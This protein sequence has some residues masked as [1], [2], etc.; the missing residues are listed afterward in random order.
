[1]SCGGS[2]TPLEAGLALKARSSKA[3]AVETDIARSLMRADSASSSV[4]MN[5]PKSES[6]E[7]WSISDAVE[8]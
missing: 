8:A 1:M 7:S 4:E 2:A 5:H 3:G 6:V